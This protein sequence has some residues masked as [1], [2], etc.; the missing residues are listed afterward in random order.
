MTNTAGDL[1]HGEGLSLSLGVERAPP[2]D[3]DSFLSTCPESTFCHLSGWHQVFGTQMGHSCFYL[4][5]RTD[6]ELR[7]VL[8]LVRV[9]NRIFG[10]YLV[11]MPFLNY[12]GPVGD[13]NACQLLILRSKELAEELDVDLLELRNRAEFDVDLPVVVRKVA[14]ILPLPGTAGELWEKSLRSKLRTKIRR[15]EKEGFE[16]RFG[17]DLVDDF[18]EIFATNMRDLGTPVLPRGLFHSLPEIFGDRV[19]F[20]ASYLEGRPVAAGCGFLWQGEFEMTWSSALQEYNRLNP[21]TLMYWEFMQRL[22]GAGARSFNFGRSTPG[23]GTHDFKRQW[24]SEDLPLPW[25]P[26]SIRGEARPP[27]P[28]QKKFA[29]ATRIWSKLPI[30]VTKLIGPSLSKWIP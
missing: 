16:T 9:R 7:G 28:D 29:L 4:S 20:G 6:G 23:S 15:S 27:T 24:G 11:S 8:P 2:S 3:W 5:A 18:Y 12:G 22:I 21:N 26:Y 17:P 13:P 30:G 10:D 14:P 1:A 25:L 19:L